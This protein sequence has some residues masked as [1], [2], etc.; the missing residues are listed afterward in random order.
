[1]TSL[2]IKL[3]IKNSKNVSDPKVRGAY[4]TLS[5]VVGILCNIILSALKLF[6]G[7]ISSSI[8]V[9][10]DAL[11]NLSDAG[12]SLVLLIG[13]KLSA[14]KP[15]ADHPFGHG[16]IEYLSG[17]IISFLIMLMGF[18]L[19]KSSVSAIVSGESSR[20]SLISAL[21]LCLSLLT[22]LWMWAF[23]RKLGK[24]ISSE[25]LIAGATDSLGDCIST[26]A[27][28]AGMLISHFLS[29]ELDGYIGALV[30]LIILYAGFKSAKD[31]I[32]PLLGRAPDPQ[33]VSSLAEL[34]RSE[35]TV[36]DI[37]DL[38]VH[39]Y[40]PGRLIASVHAEVSAG[41]S[42]IEI[43]DVMDNLERRAESELGCLL[44]I[45]MDPIDTDNPHLPAISHLVRD[46]LDDIDPQYSFHDLRIVSGP[47]HTNILF[48]ISVPAEHLK[49]ADRI[50]ESVCEKI[51]ATNEGY[52][53]VVKVEQRFEN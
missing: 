33:L 14:K 10:G 45:H 48:D 22:K 12:S 46:V 28:L 24:R 38:I 19:L 21:I 16:R 39:D 18:E 1:M 15:D 35:E 5:S 9:I 2:L 4:G 25:A 3:F 30:S 6:A 29:I 44:T 42:I 47:T 7:I 50:K 52:Y 32:S 17:L 53:A 31:T 20:F 11:N 49:Y 37:H 34:M 8:S 36:I 23:N 26:L 40:G 51:R 43:H 41:G 27:V 13:F